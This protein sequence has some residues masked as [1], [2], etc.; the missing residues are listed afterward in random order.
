MKQPSGECLMETNFTQVRQASGLHSLGETSLKVDVYQA[1]DRE[2]ATEAVLS[3]IQQVQGTDGRAGGL[4]ESY[5]APGSTEGHRPEATGGGVHFSDSANNFLIGGLGSG[6]QNEAFSGSGIGAAENMIERSG[7]SSDLESA[8]EMVESLFGTASSDMLSASQSTTNNNSSS[9]EISNGGEDGNDGEDGEDGTD[10]TDGNDGNDG[11]DGDGGGDEDCGC[12]GLPSIVIGADLGLDENLDL[13]P[14]AAE[15][16]GDVGVDIVIGGNQIDVGTDADAD[17]LLGLGD[18]D[19]LTVGSE[20]DI[21]LGLTLPNCCDPSLGLALDVATDTQIAVPLLQTALAADADA[22]AGVLAG[23]DGIFV[24]VLADADVDVTLL[25]MEAAD[26]D[27]DTGLDIGLTPEDG[28]MLSLDVVA[29]AGIE[30]LGIGDVLGVDTGL[31]VGLN[32]DGLSLDLDVGL[33]TLGLG[34]LVGLTLDDSGLTPEIGLLE[35]GELTDLGGVVDALPGAVEDVGQL[36]GTGLEDALEGALSGDLLGDTLEDSGALL[37]PVEEVLGQDLPVEDALGAVGDLLAPV[38]ETLNGITD[39]LVE[40]DGAVGGA[41]NLLDA[42]VELAVDTTETVVEAA[43]PVI[44]TVTEPV[45]QSLALLA[46]ASEP[47]EETLGSITENLTAIGGGGE[48]GIAETP[49]ELVETAVA[50]VTDTVGE[51]LGGSGDANLLSASDTNAGWLDAIATDTGT[52]GVDSLLA[53][54]ED[55]ASWLESIEL[56]ETL[57]GDSATGGDGGAVGGA[58]GDPLGDATTAGASLASQALSNISSG[59]KLG[60]LGW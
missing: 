11:G 10:G 40:T 25:G 52:N 9:T 22:H 3:S 17:L 31:D 1:D 36:L 23:P 28:L 54:A 30:A 27:L 2:L 43:A 13:G 6:F 50:T 48:D 38:D 20:N 35:S 59:L 7:L 21:G 14:V 29:D 37:A 12:I 42:I 60:G 51:L 58:L 41:F 53:G 4:L 26:V 56:L 39:G 15:I 5:F 44:D 55:P 8:S 19:V 24:D 57:G 32:E 49:N 16:G 33:E 46:E 18:A 34:S 47:L 45:G